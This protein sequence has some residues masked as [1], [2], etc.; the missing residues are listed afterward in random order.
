MCVIKNFILY[1]NKVFYLEAS[2]TNVHFRMD[3]GEQTWVQRASSINGESEKC[4][5]HRSHGED[6]TRDNVPS[7]GTIISFSSGFTFLLASIVILEFPAASKL[8]SV[9][10]EESELSA[11]KVL[12]GSVDVVVT[13]FVVTLLVVGVMI[14]ES[15]ALRMVGMEDKLIGV[16]AVL[17]AEVS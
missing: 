8:V 10:T 13:A 2:K 9:L 14:L 11:L 3:F 4:L 6:G 12:R 7:P 5:L 16:F 17:F 15:G 1:S